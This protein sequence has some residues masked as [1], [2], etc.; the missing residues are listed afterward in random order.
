M[1]NIKIM[2]I[3]GSTRG[4]KLYFINNSEEGLYLTGNGG[5]G[6]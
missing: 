1:I 2:K 6:F 4:W 5:A 3:Q